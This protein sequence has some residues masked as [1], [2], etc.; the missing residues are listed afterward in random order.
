MNLVTVINHHLN[1]FNGPEMQDNTAV[2]ALQI[3]K[4]YIV[5]ISHGNISGG[6]ETHGVYTTRNG[7]ITLFDPSK[8]NKHQRVD[9]VKNLKNQGYSVTSIHQVLHSFSYP[10]ICNDFKKV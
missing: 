2:I 9:V 10:T 8:Q 6:I 5:S 3:G 7:E 1:K 4:Y